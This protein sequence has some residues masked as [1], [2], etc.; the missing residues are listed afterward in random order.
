MK[1]ARHVN[2]TDAKSCCIIDWYA[3]GPFVTPMGRTS[4]EYNPDHVIMANTSWAVGV[5]GT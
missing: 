5:S 4:H 2:S 3:G 1:M